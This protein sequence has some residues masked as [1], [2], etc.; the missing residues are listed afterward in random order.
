MLQRTAS[1]MSTFN[2][3]RSSFAIFSQHTDEGTGC[4]ELSTVVHTSKRMC[5]SVSFG[6]AFQ[7][8]VQRFDAHME[9][10]KC[11]ALSNS[12]GGRRCFDGYC[13]QGKI[14]LLNF[15]FYHG[16]TIL[17]QHYSFGKS[18]RSNRTKSAAP[19][20]DGWSK[21]TKFTLHSLTPRKSMNGFFFMN[22]RR[23]NVAKNRGR[24]KFRTQQLGMCCCT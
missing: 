18:I 1:V 8:R 15:Y 7:Q 20:N 12:G 5:A 24:D 14:Y 19:Q 17:Q 4:T 10:I 16:S 3:F 13:K 23:I 11:S 6:I 22:E 21:A 2:R 9:R